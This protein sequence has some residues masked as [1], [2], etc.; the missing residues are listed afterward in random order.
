MASKI[1]TIPSLI[2][3]LFLIPILCD[4]VD[5]SFANKPIIE[6]EDLCLKRPYWKT[7]EPLYFFPVVKAKLLS[8]GEKYSFQSR[9]FKKNIVSFKEMTRDKIV[10]SL[11]NYEKEDTF[12]SELFI[13]HTSNHNFLQFILFQG[14][15]DITL[16]Y[17]TQ[18][19]KD[20]IRL[21]GIKLYGFCAG[22][23][24]TI[25]SLLMTFKAF[26]GGMGYDTKAKNP[27][28][29]PNIPKDMEKAN[30]RILELFNHYTPERRNNTIV[31]FDKNIIKTGDAIVISRMDLIDPLIMIGSGGRIGHCCVCAW[32]DNELYVLESQDALYWP[33]H[34]IQKNKWEDWVK[35]ANNAE[36]NVLHLPLR[37]EYRNKLDVNKAW[38]WFEN[39]VEGLPYGFK[40]FAFTWID[41]VNNS[42][43]FITTNDFEDLFFS[44]LYKFYPKG[45]DLFGTEAFNFRLKTKG[46]NIPQIIAEAARRGMTFEELMAIPEEEGLPYEGGI[47]YTCSCFVIAFWEHG[48]MFGDIKLLPN[49]F[50]PRDLYTLDIFDKEFK[51]PQE[52]IDDNPDIPYCQVTGSFKIELDNY[53]TV[54][55][56]S[57]MNE[58]CPSIGPDFIREDGC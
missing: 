52:C 15:H 9:C 43:P 4:N 7:A 47:A 51:R 16:K 56:Y 45:A 42:F 12:C 2:L 31:N 17:I 3:F 49:E 30:L 18:D 35:W 57:H 25:K 19:D 14:E 36:F 32:K 40:N 58:R 28:F 37:E 8:V 29:R 20:E 24:N 55:P 34:G 10:L 23:V 1:K 13:F 5:L 53:S 48:G 33:R 26:Y 41:T 22:F 21:N 11:Q 6:N 46:L 38:T 39:E 27:R 50:T 54:K 44:M